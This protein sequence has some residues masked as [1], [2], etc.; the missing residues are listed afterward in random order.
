V[1][2]QSDVHDEGHQT[3]PDIGTSNI[4]LKGTE[5]EITVHVCRIS[6]KT[7]YRYPTSTEFCI[8]LCE[9]IRPARTEQLEQ[10]SQKQ[11]GGIEYPKQD[12]KSGTARA[13]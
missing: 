2:I 3:E 12:S 10:D 1:G 8:K 13:G 5:F 9:E 6:D 4:G 7:F 11:T